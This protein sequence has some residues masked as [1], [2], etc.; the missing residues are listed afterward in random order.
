[1]THQPHSLTVPPGYFTA[2]RFAWGEH[3]CN[4]HLRVGGIL[5]DVVSPLNDPDPFTSRE[6][7]AHCR[8]HYRRNK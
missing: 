5:S 4:G 2:W 3:S 8:G 1:M 6:A 7:A